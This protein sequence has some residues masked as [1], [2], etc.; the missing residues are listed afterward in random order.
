MT[1]IESFFDQRSAGEFSLLHFVAAIT[2]PEGDITSLRSLSSERRLFGW[3]SH[4]TLFHEYRH[5]HDL[6]GTPCG[7]HTLL[8]VTRLLDEFLEHWQTK[9]RGPLRVPLRASAPES[10]IVRRYDDYRQLLTGIL[11]DMEDPPAGPDYKLTVRV[12]GIPM[13]IPCVP[14]ADLRFT[15]GRERL[16]PIGLRALME[17]TALYVQMFASIVGSDD[18]ARP[19]GEDLEERGRKYVQLWQELVSRGH[20]APYTVAHF[21]DHYVSGRFPPLGRVPAL[22]DAAMLYSGFSEAAYPGTEKTFDHPGG[23]FVH[24]VNTAAT[25]A[26]RSEASTS[27]LDRVAARAEL[28]PYVATLEQMASRLETR[29]ESLLPG[30]LLPESAATPLIG[31]VRSILLRDHAEIIRARAGAPDRWLLP[32]DY[33]R[34]FGSLPR[35]PIAVI[36]DRPVLSRGAREGAW[37]STWMFFLSAL[38]D[39]VEKNRLEC[40]VF[41]RFQALGTAFSFD[42]PSAPG[43]TTSCARFI[44]ASGCGVYDGAFRESQPPGCPFALAVRQLLDGCSFDS[45]HFEPDPLQR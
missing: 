14:L 10:F 6:I 8:Q 32:S 40:P 34:S 2:Q 26:S 16:W 25:L 35:P 22:A 41:H 11:G 18:P 24:L 43:R 33:L 9:G 15:D 31:D 42:D 20:L 21:Y 13:T 19:E 37:M 1:W 17:S 27:F 38:G 45:I 3:M 29:P 30:F 28:P 7:F 12:E 44:A 4:T 5:Y 39:V 23:V 36:N